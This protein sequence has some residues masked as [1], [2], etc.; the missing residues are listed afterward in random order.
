MSASGPVSGAVAGPARGT[1]GEHETRSASDTAH[2]GRWPFW[3]PV[4]VLFIGLILTGVLVWISASTYSSNERRL[5]NL[6]VKDA[7]ALFSGAFASIQTPLASAAALADATDGDTTKFMQFIGPYTTGKTP[8]FG[9][10][11]LWRLGA[12]QSGPLA[13]VGAPSEL[14]ANPSRAEMFFAHTAATRSRLGVIGLLTQAQ[15]RLGYAFTSPGL[16]GRYVVY[17]ESRPLPANRRS[18]FQSSSTFTDLHYALYLGGLQRPEDLLVTDLKTLPMTGQTASDSIPFG[19]NSF[20][21]IVSARQPLVGSFPQRL[22]W[23]I[24]I[25]GVLL[26]IG[27]ALLTLRLIQR[28]NHAE[29]LAESLEQ[30][31]DENRRLYSEQRTIAQTLQ[32]ALLPEALPKIRGVETGAR[33]EAG[34]DGVDIG[35]DWYDLIALDDHRLLLV[36][37][38]VSG[39]GV[40]AAA[41]M[42]SL[43]YAIHAYAAQNDPPETILTK[44]SK[45]VSVGSTG[46][47]ATIL[48]ALV[49]VEA[50]TLTVTSAGHLPPL[51]ISDGTGTFIQGA[52]GVPIGVNTGAT[53]TSTAV[54]TPPA[55]TLLAFTDGLVERRGES[56][57]AGLERLQH[58]ATADHSDLEELLSRLLEELRH[59]GDDDTAIAG[60]R[61]LD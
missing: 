26:S 48:C 4:A 27:A 44:L 40:R 6:R 16:T 13:T 36:V 15:P 57:D 51:L 49:D 23:L 33:Y 55:A 32:H 54:S 1:E 38:D 37:G 45:L 34:V 43:R 2:G 22:P 14:S 58:A 31:A 9:S 18:K 52:V 35:G 25:V 12:G 42:A 17:A 21:L 29:E 56:I 10:V 3:L 20:T 8:T 24:A 53:Y 61:W 59:D 60:L 30:I 39:R 11:T 47:L 28:R 46:Q 50:H 19:S 41:T 7:A 5:L